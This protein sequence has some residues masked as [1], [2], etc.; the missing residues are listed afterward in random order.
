MK[1][2]SLFIHAYSRNGIN[3]TGFYTGSF[4]DGENRRIVTFETSD[5]FPDRIDV[6]SCRVVDPS[7]LSA[8]WRGD[9]YAWELNR[10]LASHINVDKNECVHDL[11]GQPSIA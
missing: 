9:D 11:I 7:D 3:S 6:Q 5:E 1:I 10:I 4:I 2:R 8:K